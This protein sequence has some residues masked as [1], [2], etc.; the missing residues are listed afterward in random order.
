MRYRGVCMR[1]KVK[2]TVDGMRLDDGGLNGNLEAHPSLH[3]LTSPSTRASTDRLPPATPTAPETSSSQQIEGII[4]PGCEQ[5]VILH[6]ASPGHT[7][8]R[9][10]LPSSRET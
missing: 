7:Y 5:Q 8:L 4:L 1:K 6:G 2:G 3:P 10:R 9:R